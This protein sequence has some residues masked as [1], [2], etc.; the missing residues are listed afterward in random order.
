M[1]SQVPDR[2]KHSEYFM[3]GSGVDVPLLLH[4]VSCGHV[5][6]NADPH[7]TSIAPGFWTGCNDACTDWLPNN[8]K[9]LHS[10]A[11]VVAPKSCVWL[12]P[13]GLVSSYTCSS[14]SADGDVY[15]YSS[16]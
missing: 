16:L 3:M 4:G 11:A 1:S 10:I 7:S 14:M 6:V 5:A 9:S 12:M 8:H 13:E 15:E 2:A